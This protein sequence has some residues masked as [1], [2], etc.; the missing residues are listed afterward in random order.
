MK[1][2]GEL[3]VVTGGAMGMGKS[4]SRRLLEAG[5]AVALVD[6][7]AEALAS[8][9]EQLSRFGSCRPYVCD[10]ADRTA[11]YA[12][13]ETIKA[14]MGS[15]SILVNNA[16]IV[17]AAPFTELTEE[18]IENILNVN[19]TAQ[20]WTC[21]AFLPAMIAQDNGHVV[22]VASAGGILAL[23]NLSAYCASKFGVVGLTDA[24]RQEM[25]KQK[26]NVGFTVVCPNTVGTGMFEGSKMVA[27]TR[28]LDP[29]DVAADIVAGIRRNKAMVAVP[30]LPVKILTPLTKVLLPIRLMDR[31]NQMLGMWGANDTWT[32]RKENR[33][34]PLSVPKSK[35]H[36]LLKRV[37]WR[38]R[39]ARSPQPVDHRHQHFTKRHRR[40]GWPDDAADP[41]RGA[42]ARHG[43]GCRTPVKI[44]GETTLPCR[45]DAIHVRPYG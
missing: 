22:N 24:L 26:A 23:P 36:P 44:R 13:A 11:V 16:G 3:A 17:K 2:S 25:K 15:V 5:C 27:G 41:R 14:D 42:S 37:G 21:K 39:G 6:V 43:G 30:S 35:K 40:L 18:T 19:L 9:S 29:E 10:I 34:A 4:V 1:L 38:I 45:V 33:P 8:T 12:L 28:L 31:L 20:F 7:N 32:G